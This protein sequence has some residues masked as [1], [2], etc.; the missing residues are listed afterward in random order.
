ML[1]SRVLEGISKE[2][3][4]EMGRIQPQRGRENEETVRRKNDVLPADDRS[5]GAAAG[6][7]L[8]MAPLIDDSSER[9]RRNRHEMG[10]NQPK[11][12]S[13]NEEAA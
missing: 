1:R 13:E 11:R 10:R 12:R 8:Q 3:R 7:K 4:H 9:K 6:G 2:A 5:I